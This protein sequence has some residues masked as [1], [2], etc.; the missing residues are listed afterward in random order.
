MIRRPPR[1]TLFP[2]TTLFR[3]ESETAQEPPQEQ[4]PPSDEEKA[5]RKQRNDQ[6]RERRWFEER[7]A[8][9]AENRELRERLERLEAAKEQS[10]TPKENA[11]PALKQFLESGKYPT[12]ELA[13]EAYTDAVTDW[14]LD[15]RD[16]ERQS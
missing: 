15:K 11:K 10:P 16:A 2:Y 4:K 9:R 13:Q 1:S 3:S 8:I 7:G 14:K 12:Y 5:D 6:R